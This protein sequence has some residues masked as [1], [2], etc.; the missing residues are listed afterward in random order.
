MVPP[1]DRVRLRDILAAVTDA[2]SF[3]AGMTP[4]AFDDLPETDRRTYRAVKNAIS[5]IGEAVKALPPALYAR[6]PGIDWRG[7]AGLRDIVVRRYFA[8]DLT[9]LWPVMTEEFP[10]LLKAVTAELGEDDPLPPAARQS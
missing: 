7:I 4:E 3:V 1:D 5:E 9:R 6:H 10:A 2:M 8:V